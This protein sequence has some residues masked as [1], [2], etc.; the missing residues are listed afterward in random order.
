MPPT[1]CIR[2]RAFAAAVQPT[3]RRSFSRHAHFDEL[4]SFKPITAALGAA[5]QYLPPGL[6]NWTRHA[7]NAAT[8]P[9]RG[10]DGLYTA[11]SEGRFIAL[12]VGITKAGRRP[13]PRCRRDRNQRIGDGKDCQKPEGRLRRR[14]RA[15]GLRR[16]RHHWAWYMMRVPEP[17]GSRFTMRN[18]AAS[19]RSNTS[20][21]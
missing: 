16:A 4:P 12:A 18:R 8:A 13:G 10:F 5:K 17:S 6:A 20:S 21:L 2:A 9:I 7:P 3:S 1:F 11:A 19:S 14:H 15:R